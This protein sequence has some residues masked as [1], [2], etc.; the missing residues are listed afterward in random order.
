VLVNRVSRA[1][2]NETLPEDYLYVEAVADKGQLSAIVNDLAERYP[3]VE[4]AA[5]LDRIG[6]RRTLLHRR[7]TSAG[8]RRVL[9]PPNK[10][11]IIEG[12]EKQ[13][14][15]VQTQFEKASR[16]TP[17]VARS[18]SRSGTRQQPKSP[19]RWKTTCLPTT[20]STAWSPRVPVVTG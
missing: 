7:W 8:Q 2:F 10:R 14:T 20:R 15:K 16:P 11:Q 12:Y 3:K 17:S 5:A 6:G 1:L 9:T 4:V 18:S 19:R 13:A